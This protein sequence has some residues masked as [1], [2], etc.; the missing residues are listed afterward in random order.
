M[1]R[2]G[3]QAHRLEKSP[4]C[5]LPLMFRDWIELSHV[6]TGAFR[7]RVFTLSRTFWLF[8]YQVLHPGMACS[9]TVSKALSVLALEEGEIA[10]QSTSAY[11]QARMRLPKRLL[12]HAASGL[13]A[14]LTTE[15]E[16]WQWHGRVVK[17]ADGSSLSMPDTPENQVE[18]PQPS[19]Q[20]SG[21]GF[22]AMRLMCLFSLATG[23]L[24]ECASACLRQSER[25]LWRR[26]WPRLSPGDVVLGDRNFCGLAEF[27]MLA[28][29]GVDC[30]ARLNARRNAGVR[31]IRRLG[32]NDL[33]VEWVKC[34]KSQKPE[35]MTM[36]AFD[37]LPQ[38][39]PVRH[40]NV[41]VDKVGFR[42]ESITVATTLLDPKLYPARDF[43]ELYYRRWK[44]ELYLRD[45]K[46]TQGMD[47]LRCKS[48][49]MIDKEL[50]MHLIVYNLVRALM[51]EACREYPGDPASLSFKS[52]MALTRQWAPAMAEAKTQGW[53]RE[54]LELFLYYLAN[55][56]LPLPTGRSEPRAKKRRPKNYQLLNKSRHEFKAAAHRN[57]YEKPLS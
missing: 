47:V 37:A 56:E 34:S 45:I 46:I 53:H 16:H 52:S 24:L 55:T 39:V 9:E 12:K 3:A 51:V 23:A 48:P 18:Y 17:V 25:C 36:K 5:E 14:R 21:C 35:W 2:V 10:S 15:G 54:M 7:D 44:A 42:T 33:L 38:S 8:L 27:V 57:H 6:A 43:A 31:R 40:I 20:K 28:R 22:P 50:Q 1:G 4:L 41:K 11:C 32:R 19:G 29:Q 26:L 49:E 13:V 30:V